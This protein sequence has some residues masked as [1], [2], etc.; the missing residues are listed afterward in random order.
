MYLVTFILSVR[1]TPVRLYLSKL[2]EQLE[3]FVLK[4]FQDPDYHMLGKL[5]V[6]TPHYEKKIKIEFA[7]TER[8]I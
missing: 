5:L 1:R 8:R 7:K 2:K 3:D 6:K 4:K